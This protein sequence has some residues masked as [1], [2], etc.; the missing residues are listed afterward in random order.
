MCDVYRYSNITIAAS[1]AS[2]SRQGLFAA[3]DPLQCA[4]CFLFGTMYAALESKS[5][6]PW[7]LETRGWVVQEKL[8]SA[9]SIQFGS[10]ISWE[11]MELSVDEFGSATLDPFS[12]DKSS[13]PQQVSELCLE[14]RSTDPVNN[15]DV[16]KLWQ[17]ILMMYT[18]AEFSREKD[19]LTAIEGISSAIHQRTGWR[20]VCGLWEP[21]ILQD[22]LWHPLDGGFK[23][24]PTGLRPS[25]TWATFT[26]PTHTLVVDD[27]GEWTEVAKYIGVSTPANEQLQSS[28]PAILKISGTLWNIVLETVSVR[29]YERVGNYLWM[30]VHVQGWLEKVKLVVYRFRPWTDGEMLLPIIRYPRD[31]PWSL[32]RGLV[33]LP[34]REATAFVRTGL[35]TVGHNPGDMGRIARFVMEAFHG[36]DRKPHSRQTILLE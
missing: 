1:G 14:P 26:G 24:K 12:H 31:G 9:R 15:Y 10:Y 20:W 33:V 11:C 16:R 3:R 8:L 32:F 25:W 5:R 6:G 17:A 27:P 2:D 36:S 13:K 21:F 4:P 22:L 29:H 30:W 34:N 28:S 35:F 18:S 7:R 19:R 23:P